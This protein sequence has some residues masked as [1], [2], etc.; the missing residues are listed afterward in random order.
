M[1]NSIGNYDENENIKEYENYLLDYCFEGNIDKIKYLISQG[2]NIDCQ[3]ENKFTPL[4]LASQEDHLN[5]VKYLIS[6]GANI[7]CQDKDKS[8]PL[9][10]ASS[11]G[12]LNIVKYLISQGANIE[13]Q[14][15]EKATPL[16]LS[17][18]EHYS[19]ISKLLILFGS[20][21]QYKTSF[22]GITPFHLSIFK[23]NPTILELMIL[24]GVNIN[25]TNDLH[26]TAYSYSIS[27]S[28][29]EHLLQ[30]FNA[31]PFFTPN[32]KIGGN[33]KLFQFQISN[34]SNFYEILNMFRS[35]QHK[36]VCIT[37]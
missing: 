35:F 31:N 33:I 13:C 36:N 30:N 29:C 19:E 24:H 11:K 28:E 12:H 37:W 27:N 7:E 3:N 16:L 32:D 9:H 26:Q 20:N 25:I 10:I 34:C 21:L 18:I 5:I 22:F 17:M 15:I 4:H 23:N 14:T 1:N 8:T 6:Q 2:A